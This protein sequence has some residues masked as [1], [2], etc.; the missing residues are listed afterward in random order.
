[1][2]SEWTEVFE[3]QGEVYDVLYRECANVQSKRE[4]MDTGKIKLRPGHSSSMDA[5]LR[6]I[7]KEVLKERKTLLVTREHSRALH[8]EDELIVIILPNILLVEVVKFWGRLVQKVQNHPTYLQEDKDAIKCLSDAISGRDSIY[9]LTDI[10]QSFEVHELTFNM[11]QKWQRTYTDKTLIRII[12]RF[13]WRQEE[14]VLEGLKAQEYLES[15]IP[16]EREK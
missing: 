13:Q 8:S 9:A 5:N 7:K 12:N 4:W 10:Q 14:W 3:R 15:V 6:E 11:F 2:R 1:M 16:Y